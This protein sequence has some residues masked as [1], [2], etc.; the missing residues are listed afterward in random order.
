MKKVYGFGINDSE[1]PVQTKAWVDGVYK[2]N[3]RCPFYTKWANM[4]K[5]CYGADS[6]YKGCTVDERWLT[7]SNFRSWMRKHKWEGQHLDKDLF[8]DKVYS[9]DT[10]VFI[11]NEMNSFIKSSVNKF[12]LPRGVSK[13]T[14]GSIYAHISIEGKNY[15][16]GMYDS[17]DDAKN[18]Y[19]S[20]KIDRAK[21]IFKDQPLDIL[22]AIIRRLD[23]EC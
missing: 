22:E 12:G 1:T 21:V 6:D 7:F 2:V 5:R 10:C 11:S 23:G 17:I 20:A 4:L 8:G 16:L 13:S 3:W 19:K 15:Y 14:S 18:A 9:P